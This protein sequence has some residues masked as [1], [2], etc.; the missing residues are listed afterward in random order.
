MERHAMAPGA[1]EIAANGYVAAVRAVS[2]AI[3]TGEVFV[4]MG[5]SGSGKSSLIR[6][7]SRLV[8]PTAGEIRIDGEDILRLAERDLT[9]LRRGKI[10]MVFQN[11]ALLPHDTVLGNVAFPLEIRGT[12]RKL[13]EQR[14]LEMI[15][16]VGLSGRENHYPRELSGGQQQRVGIARALTINP[17][18]LLLD[19]PF[20]ALDPLIRTEMQ[21]EL[22]ALQERIQKTIVFITHDFDEAITLADRMAIMRDGEIIQVGTPEELVT[23]PRTDYVRE[24]TKD[25]ARARVL[26]VSTLMEP[27]DGCSDTRLRVAASARIEAVAALLIDGNC[28]ALAVDDGGMPVGLLAKRRVLD[29]LLNRDCRRDAASSTVKPN[30]V[31]HPL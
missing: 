2:L 19:E 12:E 31:R 7:L 9:E 10:A 30:E 20:S 6:C 26:R 15:E 13:R 4:V 16:V 18:I 24:F 25:V 27:V 5:L 28:D 23:A 8:E 14:A 29:A 1:A 21:R 17:E 22:M 11:F 3:A